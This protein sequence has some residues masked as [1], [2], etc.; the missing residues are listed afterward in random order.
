[1]PGSPASSIPVDAR[2]ATKTGNVGAKADSHVVEP[3][4]NEASA[5]NFGLEYRSYRYPHTG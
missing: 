4:M 1:M 3:Q 2:V 5:S